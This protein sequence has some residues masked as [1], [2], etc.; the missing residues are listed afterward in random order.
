MEMRVLAVDDEP[1]VLTAI[2][3]LLERLSCT[4]VAIADSRQAAERL[5][6]EQFDGVFL[7]VR[8]PNLDGF[9][10]AKRVR[11][12]SLNGQAPIVMFTGLDDVATMR[13]G[14][15]AGASCF[16]GKP[17][18]ADRITNLVKAMRSAMLGVR[19]R[20]ARLP[21]RTPVT[22]KAGNQN[23]K[24][25][26]INISEGG[27]VLD[28]SGGWEVGQEVALEFVMPQ[29]SAPIKVRAKIVHKEPTGSMAVEF[30]DL[31]NTARDAIKK[32]ITG[33]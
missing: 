25:T 5:T 32:Y 29:A 31:S 9:E 23:L 16:L 21:L 12:S 2:K 14:F 24:S 1:E 13:E 7:D 27:M 26:S 6:K 30:L 28:A 20:Y 15:K 4:V 22:C 17:V 10:L 8:M 11:A 19:R 3:T 33:T 18:S